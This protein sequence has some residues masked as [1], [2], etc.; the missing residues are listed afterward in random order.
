MQAAAAAAAP[1]HPSPSTSSSSV[2]SLELDYAA[3]ASA[4]RSLSKSVAAFQGAADRLTAGSADVP[5]LAEV[6]RRVGDEGGS[7]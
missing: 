1:H 3:V 2:P 6:M 5:T 7:K 4:L